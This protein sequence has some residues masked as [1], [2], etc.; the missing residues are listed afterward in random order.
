[1]LVRTHIKNEV[2]KKIL[3]EQENHAKEIKEITTRLENEKINLEKDLKQQLV[4]KETELEKCNIK[5]QEI[6]NKNKFK[7]MSKNDKKGFKKEIENIIGAKGK[8]R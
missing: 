4:S 6:E 3:Q 5:Y 7:D 8:K 1:M 2:S